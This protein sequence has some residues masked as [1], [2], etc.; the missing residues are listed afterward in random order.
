[1]TK[2]KVLMK[3]EDGTEELDDEY[4]FDSEKDAEE[5]AWYLCSCCQ[6]GA[7]TLHMSNPGDYPETEVEVDYEIVEVEE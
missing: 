2:Y 1:M 7:E 5:Y 3:Y 4:V 6:V